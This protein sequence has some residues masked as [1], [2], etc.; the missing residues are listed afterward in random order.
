[1]MGFN[2]TPEEQH[3]V[4]EFNI[5]SNEFHQALTVFMADLGKTFLPALTGLLHAGSGLM[6]MFTGGVQNGIPGAPGAGGIP[7]WLAPLFPGG[8]IGAVGFSAV[9]TG[10]QWLL[11]KLPHHA[12]GG[13]V[14]AGQLSIVGESGPEMFVPNQPGA[15]IPNNNLAGMTGLLSM[16]PN[17]GNS[18]SQILRDIWQQIDAIGGAAGL[19][20]RPLKDFV[21]LLGDLLNAWKGAGWVAMQQEV[22]IW[23]QTVDV[24][25]QTA[26]NEITQL[27]A[28]LAEGLPKDVIN[29]VMGAVP[30][31]PTLPQ[32]IVQIVPKIAQEAYDE[33]LAQGGAY[34]ELTHDRYMTIFPS[35]AQAAY[36]ALFAQPGP[37]WEMTHDRSLS[38]VPTIDT[39]SVL[40]AINAIPTV[41]NIGVKTVPV[42]TTTVA[43]NTDRA[44]GGVTANAQTQV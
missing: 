19:A 8:P 23:G 37:F 11:D 9:G 17:I 6:H 7:P 12:G 39:S 43:D 5:A 34:W 27:E 15:I 42:T 26:I 25:V 31:L 20:S 38:I 32:I 2:L 24:A 1:M 3:D 41:I 14:P 36:D 18:V 44:N 13:P 33:L 4:D 29:F 10:L 35:L 21:G 40:A 22:L 16:I 28:K 30:A